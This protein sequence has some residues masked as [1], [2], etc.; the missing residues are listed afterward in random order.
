MTAA[1]K[2]QGPGLSG[3]VPIQAT[4]SWT[5][6]AGFLIVLTIPTDFAFDIS[7]VLFTPIRLYLIVLFPIVVVRYLS[8][9]QGRPPLFDLL[10]FLFVMWTFVAILL[11]RGPGA[12]LERGGQFFLEFG[13]VYMLARASIIRKEQASTLIKI[14]FY[15]ICVILFFAVIEA[16]IYRGP[17]I[18]RLVD[19][20]VGI[21]V[22]YEIREG[23][24][25]LGLYRA[26]TF[27]GHAI[28]MGV[29]V[30]ACFS[31]IVLSSRNI[32]SKI[33][34]GSIVFICTFL[35]LSSGPL[36][37]VLI[38]IICLFIYYCSE[39][40][41]V[42]FN[43]ILTGL[44]LWMVAMETFTGRGVVGT[45]ELLVLD[46]Q[47]YHYRVL[48]WNQGID[49]V[50]RNPFFG[51]REE[52]WTRLHWMKPSIDNFWLLQSMRG[53]IPSTLFLLGSMLLLAR[54][55]VHQ[56][57]DKDIDPEIAALRRGCLF[58]LLAFFLCGAAVHFF[59]KVQPFFALMLGFTGAVS[60]LV[61]LNKE[62]RSRA[63]SGA[64]QSVRQAVER[65]R[66]LSPV[67]GQI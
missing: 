48:I 45:V 15:I 30:G 49:D 40:L 13:V 3:I 67:I 16:A 24:F 43:T 28:I 17:L 6:A 36:L 14:L 19:K 12:G 37:A 25:R 1:A 9:V 59:D 11:N 18:A 23:F 4:S 52:T 44:F 54:T 47:N 31:L 2:S 55:M 35:S 61:V 10:Y 42:N 63:L 7:G 46:P 33:F 64:G 53:G 41:N 58:M 32:G 39:K 62:A 22:N 65:P 38:Q 21:P 56:T 51:F 8:V 34:R 57:F 66:R 20:I 29:F 50:L 5:L 26:R 60:R 27:F